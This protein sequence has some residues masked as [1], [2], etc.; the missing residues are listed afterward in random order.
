MV[1]RGERRD[2]D[3][4]EVSRQQK[5]QNM[6]R[7]VLQYLVPSGPS[8][9]DEMNP[10]WRLSVGYH[11]GSARDELRFRTE[12]DRRPNFGI[13][14]GFHN[15]ELVDQRF[16]QHPTLRHQPF[17]LEQRLGGAIDLDH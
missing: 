11:V 15:C 3:V 17:G 16:V 7:S 10:L 14:Q 1:H 8:S 6:P 12:I 2:V 5:C 9:K 4:A 13:G